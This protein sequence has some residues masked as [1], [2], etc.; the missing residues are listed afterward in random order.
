MGHPDSLNSSD[1]LFMGIDGGGSSCRAVLVTA[2]LDVLATGSAGPANPYHSFEG[3]IGSLLAASQSALETAGLS[4][5][6]CKEIRVGA[7]L[8]GVNLP[9][10]FQKMAAWQHPFKAFHLTTDMEIACLGAHAGRDGAVMIAGTGSSGCAVVNGHVSVV[11]AYGYPFADTGSG[12]WIG[13]Q[14]IRAVLSA[15]DGLGIETTLTP[16]LEQ[17]LGTTG[18]DIVERL[19]DS[20][21]KDFAEHAKFVFAAAKAG[22][23]VAVE[24]LKEAATYLDGLAQRLMRFGTDRL[25]FIGGLSELLTEW[26]PESTAAR[27]SKPVMSPEMG[28]CMF[29]LRE[30]GVDSAAAR[31]H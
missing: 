29:A 9:A 13:L 31:C 3:T 11:G 10:V 30:S 21:T 26:L 2:D 22:D 4:V 20:G 18:N 25:S 23:A 15:R 5:E 19:M 8:A 17:A 6:T 7:G 14:G 24:I 27:I 16:V 1:Q 12:A 28:A